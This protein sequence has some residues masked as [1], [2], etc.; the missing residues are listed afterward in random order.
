MMKFPNDADGQV[1]KSLYDDGVNFSKPQNVDFFVA[2]PDE[3][4]GKQILNILKENG[5]ECELTFDD[6]SEEWTCYCYLQILLKYE[7]IIQIQN[8]L[9]ELSEPLGGYSD[10]WGVMVE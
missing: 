9:G 2:V 1:L 7:D 5:F 3:A 10:G 6:D 4:N 8:R